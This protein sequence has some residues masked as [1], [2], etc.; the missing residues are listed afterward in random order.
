MIILSILLLF[1]STKIYQG[2]SKEKTN[3][4]K[5]FLPFLV[6][7][8]HY[9]PFSFFETDITLLG[10]YAVSI[11]F[12]ISG[13]GLTYKKNNNN[14]SIS[15]RYISQKIIKLMIPLFSSAIIYSLVN[16]YYNDIN[17]WNNLFKSLQR[18]H[19]LF[20]MSWF[21]IKII[22]LYIFFYLSSKTKNSVIVL[23]ALT[24]SCMTI[25]KLLNFNGPS[26]M[27]DLAFGGGTLYFYLEKRGLINLKYSKLPYITIIIILLLQIKGTIY[28]TNLLLPFFCSSPFL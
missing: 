25:E 17:V 5:A 19:F 23:F 26:F 18:G 13:Y 9:F 3:L 6:V 20:P 21:V 14:N 10:C 15:L 27:S 11:F 7:I 1:F 2:F 16:F 4:L 12:F 24:I 22:I 8:S 28:F